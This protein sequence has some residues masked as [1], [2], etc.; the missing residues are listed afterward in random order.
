MESYEAYHAAFEAPDEDEA[1][2]LLSAA[3]TPTARFESEHSGGPVIGYEDLVE[4]VLAMRVALGD[5]PVTRSPY[6]R[7]GD[8]VMWTWTVMMPGGEQ[9]GRDVALLASDGRIEQLLVFDISPD[10]T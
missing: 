8:A 10:T 4:H 7:V 9:S 5:A 1:R 2:R 3:F 6:R